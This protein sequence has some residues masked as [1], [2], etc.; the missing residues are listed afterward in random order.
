M[1]YAVIRPT[2]CGTKVIFHSRFSWLASLRLEW[3]KLRFPQY[4]KVEVV[5]VANGVQDVINICDH[6]QDLSEQL[7][8]ATRRCEELESHYGVAPAVGVLYGLV[9]RNDAGQWTTVHDADTYVGDD[10]QQVLDEVLA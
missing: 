3:H 5:H 6:R 4:A 7:E 9:S 8:A 2:P 1:A 10:H